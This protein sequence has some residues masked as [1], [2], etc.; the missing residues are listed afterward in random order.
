M[1]IPIRNSPS[2]LMNSICNGLGLHIA[3]ASASSA[4][5]VC[6]NDQCSV[7][8]VVFEPDVLSPTEHWKLP[9]LAEHCEVHHKPVCSSVEHNGVD[10]LN[11][12]LMS[13]N[14]AHGRTA[15]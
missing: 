11:L 9:A 10:Q 2:L 13:Y 8:L 6:N 12:H 14:L 3:S 1:V 15:I 5:L 4:V 7:S